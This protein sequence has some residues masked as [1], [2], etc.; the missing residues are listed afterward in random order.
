MEKY[1][2]RKWDKIL[3]NDELSFAESLADI[4]ICG[5]LPLFQVKKVV[6][7]IMKYDD[8]DEL[9]R[10]FIYELDNKKA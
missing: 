10:S 7:E 6:E 9:V 3:T 4:I 5:D 1:K 8:I 2:P